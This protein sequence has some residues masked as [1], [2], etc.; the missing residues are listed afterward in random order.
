[1]LDERAQPNGAKAVFQNSL[2]ALKIYS[3]RYV[4]YRFFSTGSQFWNTA[5]IYLIIFRLRVR[6]GRRN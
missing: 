4:Y 3:L 2:P 5:K 1:M 6:S